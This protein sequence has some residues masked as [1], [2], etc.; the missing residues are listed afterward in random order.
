MKVLHKFLSC[1]SVIAVASVCDTQTPAAMHAIDVGSLDSP[2]A[3]ATLSGSHSTHSGPIQAQEEK[4]FVQT[5]DGYRLFYRRIGNGP[6]AILVPYSLFTFDGLSALASPDRTLVFYDPRNR[7]ESESVK[8]LSNISV[9]NDIRDMETLREHFQFKTLSLIGYS[10]YGMEVAL[11]AAEHPEHVSHLVQL[12][13][14]P[15]KYGTPYP[16]EFDNTKDRS[17]FDETLGQKIQGMRAAHKDETD[18][19]EFCRVSLEMSKAGLVTTPEALKRLQ[20]TIDHV[21]DYPNE[22]PANFNK[23]MIAHFVGSVM[24]MDV[25]WSRLTKR[26]TMPVLTI[27]GRKDRNAPYGA[28]WE[29]SSKLTNARF[30]SLDNA[31]HQSWVDEP[32]IVLGAIDQFLGGQW[33]KAAVTLHQ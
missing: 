9:E 12:G 16:A 7:G 29:W 4:G 20:P 28:G 24:K 22:W 2:E 31:A 21:C 5:H 19:K 33:P 17:V 6:E 18:P 32:E 1:L 25:P 8:D 3:R 26:V 14:V 30:L 10:V 23:Q 27:H 13:P 15:L 11:Y